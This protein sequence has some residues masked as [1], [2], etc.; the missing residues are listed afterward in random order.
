[1]RGPKSR[2]LLTKLRAILSFEKRWEARRLAEMA[3]AFGPKDSRYIPSQ[4]WTQLNAINTAQL[5]AGGFHN[6]K[7]TIN[8][9]YFNW[10]PNDLQNNQVRT[11]LKLWADAP[12]P[13]PIATT[14]E[15]PA[16]LWNMFDQ[17]VL[18]TAVKT[19]TYA[20][21]VGLLWWFASL[22]DEQRLTEQLSEPALGNPLRIRLGHRLIS[23]DLANSIREYTTVRRFLA[24]EPQKIMELGAGYGRLAY[25]FLKASNCKYLIFDIPPA[26]YLAERYLSEV[27]VDKN[28]F[29]F[30]KFTKFADIQEELEKADV[31]FF[32]ANQMELF[33]DGYFDIALAISALHEMR[34]DQIANYLS[35]MSS[36][37]SRAV[38]LKNWRQWH[39]VAD[40]VQ[41]TEQTFQ[42]PQ[43]WT[44][45]LNR[46]DEVQ[47][48]FA[49]KLFY[50]GH[51]TATA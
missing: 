9:N 23:E 2:E 48:M 27:L 6:F 5:S 41:I 29:R 7:R 38:Y 50:R 21:F 24:P 16:D 34:S 44:L 4:F 31:G 12:N 26:L 32:T 11:L 36:L 39:N 37:S 14:V 30:R 43:P 3:S 17:N 10:V 47:G 1:M 51:R 13:T 33:P 40:N 45:V 49:E 18:D 22:K 28:V 35:M 42:L 20:F 8:Q 19:K 25:V 15:G 46:V